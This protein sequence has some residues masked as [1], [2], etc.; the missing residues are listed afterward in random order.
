[1]ELHHGTIEVTSEEN[2][3]TCIIVRIPQRPA[4]SADN[5]TWL[6]GGGQAA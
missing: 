4:A 1:V 2:R 6:A 3:G 5:A